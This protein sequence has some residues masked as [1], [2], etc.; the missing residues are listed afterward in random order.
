MAWALAATRRFVHQP[1]Q[2]LGPEA[3]GAGA[4]SHLARG[5]ATALF[6]V[7]E[8]VGQ[9]DDCRLALWFGIVVAFDRG[10]QRRRQPPAPDQHASDQSMVDA[11]LPVLLMDALLRRIRTVAGLGRVAGVGVDQHELADVVQE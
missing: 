11:E 6:V 5:D 7:S 1:P 9:L 4:L 8:H 10:G 2:L 3:Y